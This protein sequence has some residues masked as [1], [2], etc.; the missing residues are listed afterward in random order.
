LRIRARSCGKAVRTAS[1]TRLEISIEGT[2][3]VLS[4]R[5]V[6]TLNV[7]VSGRRASDV[8][9]CRTAAAVI[10][11]SSG[12]TASTGLSETTPNTR[13]R[14]SAA[15]A[16]GASTSTRMRPNTTATDAGLTGSS[17]RRT[18]RTKLSRK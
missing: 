6:S 2:G 18:F 7:A 15:T 9:A 16:A 10:A 1:P 17:A 3:N 12:G 5:R 13:R 14:H 4:A 11:S 8:P